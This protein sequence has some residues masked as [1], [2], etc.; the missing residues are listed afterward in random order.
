VGSRVTLLQRPFSTEK[1]RAAIN[2]ALYT[3]ER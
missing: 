2:A 3:E 1:L